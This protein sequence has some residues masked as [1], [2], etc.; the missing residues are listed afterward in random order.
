MKK[1]T[2]EPNSKTPGTNIKQYRYKQ[3]TTRKSNA[4]KA[5][6]WTS[7]RSAAEINPGVGGG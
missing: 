4:L 2:A 5:G 3:E 6:R 1:S 7:T